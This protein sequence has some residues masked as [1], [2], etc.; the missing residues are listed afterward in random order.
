MIK[1]LA[2]KNNTFWY[3]RK[4]DKFGE[5][6]L[7]LK[8]KNYDIAI[9]RHS[10]IDYKIKEL[11]YKGAFKNMTVQEIRKLIDKYKNY[12]LNEEYNDFE[13]LRN[14]ELEIEINGKKFAGHTKQ[15]IENKINYYQNIHSED[16]VKLLDLEINKILKRSNLTKYD[17]ENLKT[18]KDKMIFKWEVL[19]AELEILY[20]E[21][22][23]QEEVIKELRKKDYP[24]LDPEFL[25]LI[26]NTPPY[27]PKINDITILELLESYVNENKES[28][29]WSDKNCRDIEYVLKLFA[30]YYDNKFI[31]QL[32]RE[33]F[34]Q[35]RD[36]I[37]KNLPK[38]SQ[39]KDFIN[40][41][42]VE[43]IKI[44][45]NKNLEKIGIT[46]I[47]KH[48]RR[49]H[50]VFE[51]AVNTDKI[52]KN[53]TKDLKIIDKKQ[54]TKDKNKRVPYS[55]ED[56]IKLFH[57]SP[58][59]NEELITTL[60]FEPQNVFIPLLILFTG[61]KPSELGTLKLTSIKMKD[62]IYGIDFNL[63]IKNTK[64]ERFTPLSQTLIEL[65]FLKYI[66]YQKKLKETMLFPNI[67]IF[68]SGGINFT[69]DFT[70]Y[71][72]KYITT[73]ENKTF[74][75]FRHLV[76]QMLKNKKTPLYIINDIVG[77][78]DGKGNKDIEVYGDKFMPEKILSDTIN[79]CLVY[80]FLDFSRIKEAI[81]TV[82]K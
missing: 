15:A 67:R 48:L 80:N 39:N 18:D 35:F 2:K 65:G 14:K 16:N 46:T 37:L 9:L 24:P 62:E 23:N 6:L 47:N 19:K 68:K 42:A 77:H 70:I 41:S 51:W 79:E 81:N 22:Y 11:I 20:N 30:S 13:E 60:K 36:N 57:N 72:R 7:S 75:S 63:M 64:T 25:K 32:K 12:M 1:Y 56:L 66:S 34:T 58:W 82:Y 40:K 59:Y 29:D 78:S 52:S 17:L 31:K 54:S 27:N 69:N 45:K 53:L 21:Y 3:R 71:N 10:Y 33:H 43:I 73:D 38:T 50:Q 28:K 26:L 8:T 76:N 5:V 49:I 61:A 74:Y 44:V 4:I 55:N